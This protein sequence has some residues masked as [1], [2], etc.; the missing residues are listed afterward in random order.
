VTS[1]PG[2]NKTQLA[3]TLTR[4]SLHNPIYICATLYFAT[5]VFFVCGPLALPRCLSWG[6]EVGSESGHT[7]SLNVGTAVNG[8]QRNPPPP[9]PPTHT[10]HN[11]VCRRKISLIE[12]NAK[13]LCLKSDLQQD[14]VAAGYLF[15]VPSPS[16]F[17]S[18]GG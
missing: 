12:D 18:W 8:L 4:C 10:L 6:A 14:F 7:Q 16:R 15:G 13:F 2:I 17:L 3:D 11:S 1:R 9:P 5:D